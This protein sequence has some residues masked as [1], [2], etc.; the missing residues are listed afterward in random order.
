M[1]QAMNQQNIILEQLWRRTG[2]GED[3]VATEATRENYAW[4]LAPTDEN[5]VNESYFPTFSG[6]TG[7]DTNYPKIAN[8][9]FEWLVNSSSSV[10][11]MVPGEWLKMSGTKVFFP[12]YPG[13]GDRIR[14]TK[15]V[16]SVEFSSL[17]DFRYRANT[18]KRGALPGGIGSIIELEYQDEWLLV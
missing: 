16:K 15:L 5:E 4:E 7:S 1:I 6:E 18:Y 10:Y 14:I 11:T 9:S 8:E 13:D 12:D 17:Q 3:L 2:G